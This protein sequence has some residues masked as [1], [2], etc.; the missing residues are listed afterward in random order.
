MKQYFDYEVRL[1]MYIRT[2]VVWLN[3]LSNGVINVW[4]WEIFDDVQYFTF[5]NEDD[6]VAF[7]L[8]HIQ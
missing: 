5:K 6:A 3:S 2:D 8:L 4:H 1:S 7:K